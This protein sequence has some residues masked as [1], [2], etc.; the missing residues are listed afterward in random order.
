MLYL[1]NTS[2]HMSTVHVIK[3][4]HDGRTCWDR[5]VGSCAWVRSN[6][7]IVFGWGEGSPYVRPSLFQV[8]GPV[9]RKGEPANNSKGVCEQR[10]SRG[11]WPVQLM[12]EDLYEP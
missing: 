1:S 5:A 12:P 10:L 7:R 2:M 6:I 4:R 9:M 8:A 11:M 3:E